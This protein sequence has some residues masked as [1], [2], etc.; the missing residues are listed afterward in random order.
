MSTKLFYSRTE[1]NDQHRLYSK[2]SD[3]K[4]TGDSLILKIKINL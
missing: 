3:I 2:T 4:S 1:Q